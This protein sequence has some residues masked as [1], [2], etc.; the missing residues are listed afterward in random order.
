MS[1]DV[2]TVQFNSIIMCGIILNSL[3]PGYNLIRVLEQ[4]VFMQFV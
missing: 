2:L 3:R 1:Y 4:Y